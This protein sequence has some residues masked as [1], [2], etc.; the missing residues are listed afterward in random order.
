MITQVMWLSKLL[1]PHPRQ[2][3]RPHLQWRLVRDTVEDFKLK[4]LSGP[5]WVHNYAHE[6]KN[7][8]I[9]TVSDCN[10]RSTACPAAVLRRRVL[11]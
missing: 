3:Q 4:T 10:G 11:K 2:K 6:D 5:G 1:L 7:A 9:T 8:A